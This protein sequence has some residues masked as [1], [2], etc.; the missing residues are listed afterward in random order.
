[1]VMELRAAA[2]LLLLAIGAQ[3][4]AADAQAGKAVADARCIQCHEADDWSGEDAAGLESLIADIVA[5]KLK[6][7]QTLALSPA[8]IANIAAY[9]AESS[10]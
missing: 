4:G 3:V 10:R 7:K 1:M 5:G 2:G 6:H 9:W 8:E